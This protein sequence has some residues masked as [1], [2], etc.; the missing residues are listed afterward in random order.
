MCRGLRLEAPG[1][2]NLQSSLHASFAAAMNR[3]GCSEDEAS[4]SL[5]TAGAFRTV[6]GRCLRRLPGASA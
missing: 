6:V 3:V 4:G 2:H 5:S 1:L